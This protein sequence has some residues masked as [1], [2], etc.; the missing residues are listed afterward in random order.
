MNKPKLMLEKL[1]EYNDKMQ[2]MSKKYNNEP[3]G[4]YAV[5]FQIEDNEEVIMGQYKFPEGSYSI[6]SII[7]GYI[8]WKYTPKEI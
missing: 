4:G 2:T 1:T 7:R 3:A 8:H 5:V 6:I